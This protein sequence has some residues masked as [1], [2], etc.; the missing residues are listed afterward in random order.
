MQMF[1]STLHPHTCTLTS[2]RFL[3]ALSFKF[4]HFFTCTHECSVFACRR[5]ATCCIKSGRLVAGTKSSARR[6][7]HRKLSSARG[8]WSGEGSSALN[9]SRKLLLSCLGVMWPSAFDLCCRSTSHSPFQVA[10]FVRCWRW[11]SEIQT[12]T[13]EPPVW[14]MCSLLVL[15]PRS[16]PS[17]TPPPLFFYS[18]FLK[19]HTGLW[20]CGRGD[21]GDTNRKNRFAVRVLRDWLTV[22]NEHVNRSATKSRTCTVGLCLMGSGWNRPSF[23]LFSYCLPHYAVLQ[24]K[25]MK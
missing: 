14:L 2:L 13:R 21:V 12:L 25:R 4:F 16:F 22:L 19:R 24:L 6:S 23:R 5:Y 18:F 11:N 7:C 9:Q 8:L 1:Y 15:R 17:L 3:S 10:A 20:L